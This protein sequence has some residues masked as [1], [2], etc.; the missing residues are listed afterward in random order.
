MAEE[1]L[2]SQG[3]PH[4]A[5]EGHIPTTLTTHRLLCSPR[6]SRSSEVGISLARLGT[7][8]P[9]TMSGGRPFARVEGCTKCTSLP[10]NGSGLGGVSE[11]GFIIRERARFGKNTS[12]GLTHTSTRRMRDRLRPCPRLRGCASSNTTRAVPE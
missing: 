12:S 10:G 2:I 3:Q 5:F 7:P 11:A 9:A 4:A 8:G 1:R 6:A